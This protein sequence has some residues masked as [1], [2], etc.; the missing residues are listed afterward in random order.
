MKALRTFLIT[1]EVA[2]ICITEPGRGC[3]PQAGKYLFDLDPVPFEAGVVPGSVPVDVI[4][5]V[6][7]LYLREGEGGV[8]YTCTAL[9]NGMKPRE[10]AV[11]AEKMPLQKFLPITKASIM[12]FSIID[13]ADKE[14]IPAQIKSCYQ[15]KTVLHTSI[16]QVINC[17]W[18]QNTK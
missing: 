16:N 15:S 10:R 11:S 12:L 8:M 18:N 13:S 2:N 9:G 3:Q 5:S 1:S 17:I 14:V 4:H 6:N 7:E